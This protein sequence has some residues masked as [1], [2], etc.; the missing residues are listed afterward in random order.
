[1]T[2]WLMQFIQNIRIRSAQY[3]IIKLNTE[4]PVINDDDRLLNERLENRSRK[5]KAKYAVRPSSIAATS[6]DEKQKTLWTA[7]ISVVEE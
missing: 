7:N 6:S 2:E 5:A 3:W 1:M 4:F